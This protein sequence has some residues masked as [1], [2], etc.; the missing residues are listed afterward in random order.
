[1]ITRSGTELL[2]GG[3]GASGTEAPWV[4]AGSD[5]TPCDT[6]NGFRG[7]SS[8]WVEDD[9]NGDITIVASPITNSLFTVSGYSSEDLI[10][11]ST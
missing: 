2:G 7:V 9:E 4:L 6:G 1:V 8:V 10:V 3:K 11:N 5:L